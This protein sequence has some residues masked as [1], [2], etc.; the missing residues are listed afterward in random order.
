[1]QEWIGTQLVGGVRK[2][3]VPPVHL[4]GH[5]DPPWEEPEIVFLPDPPALGVPGRVCVVLNNPT[6]SA[7]S[8]TVTFDEADFGAGIGFTPIGTQTF[9]LPPNSVNKYCIPWTPAATGTAHRCLLVHLNQDNY[10][11]MRSQRNVD[12]VRY[13]GSLGT[14]DIPVTIGN[15]DLVDHHV[16]FELTTSG[17]NPSVATPVIMPSPGDPPPDVILGGGSIIVHLQFVVPISA[18]AGPPPEYRFGDASQVSVG[19]FLDGQPT[20]GFTLLLGNTKT[21]VPVVKK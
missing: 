14:L 20:S 21:F 5:I 2:L 13:T 15:P 18:Q 3:D 8:V 19:V 17:I 12:L 10:L 16:T 7:K 6:P 1:V 11:E 4:P 9:T